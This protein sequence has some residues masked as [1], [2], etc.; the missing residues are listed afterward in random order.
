MRP[1]REAV[2]E[3]VSE[4]VEQKQSAAVEFGDGA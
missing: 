3:C 4:L 1:W 2:E